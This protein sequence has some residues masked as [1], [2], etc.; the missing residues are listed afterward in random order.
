MVL[1]LSLQ[2]A[3]EVALEK[4]AGCSAFAVHAHSYFSWTTP[5]ALSREGRGMTLHVRSL[6]QS[7]KML[8][9]DNLVLTSALL[10]L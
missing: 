8:D 5:T 9:E 1:V 4:G 10:L 6:F 2:L 3:T 7:G